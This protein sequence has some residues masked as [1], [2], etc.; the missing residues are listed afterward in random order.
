MIAQVIGCLWFYIGNYNMKRETGWIYNLL[1]ETDMSQYDT[2][3][4]YIT[5]LY[6]VFATLSTLGYG[7][8]YAQAMN[9]YLFTM[10]IEFMG[11]FLF[12][13]TMGN[14]NN[15]IEKLDDDHN[16]YLENEVEQL[17]QWLMKIDRAN[18]NNR[19]NAKLVENI[20]DTLV[21]YWKMDH[22]VVQKYGFL[23]Q[24]PVQLRDELIVFL[25]QSFIKS[26]HIFFSGLEEGFIQQIVINLFPRKFGPKDEII[27]KGKGSRHIYFIVQGEVCISS[28]DE[29]EKYVM[30][31]KG[32]YFGDYLV[33]FKLRSSNYFM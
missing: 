32:S 31:R 12:A 25:F 22:L 18:P 28:K 11:V 13:Y 24:L 33:F 27:T 17:D 20:K 6:W 29:I 30:L 21:T 10:V 4:T 2:L 8:F 23:E 3:T 14:I 5:S 9:E 1:L 7:D 19:L 16:E 26:F 15:L